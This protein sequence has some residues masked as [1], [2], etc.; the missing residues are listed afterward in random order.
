M[1]RTPRT[2]ALLLVVGIVLLVSGVAF[3]AVAAAHRPSGP[4]GGD[5]WTVLLNHAGLRAGAYGA[6]VA[7]AFLAVRG[8][9][10]RRRPG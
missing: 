8:W 6:V 2:G 1:S 5:T 4:D 10:L 3:H 9:N 7:G